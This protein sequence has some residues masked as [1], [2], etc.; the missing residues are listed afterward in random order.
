MTNTATTIT[1][2]GVNGIQ[3]NGVVV[4]PCN[5]NSQSPKLVQIVNDPRVVSAPSPLITHKVRELENTPGLRF[6]GQVIKIP[7][8]KVSFLF[9]RLLSQLA[10]QATKNI[11]TRLQKPPPEEQILRPPTSELDE[12]GAPKVAQGLK[13][14][15]WFLSHLSLCT[16][17]RFVSDAFRPEY[18]GISGAVR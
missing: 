8:T 17:E 1:A 12:T 18:P 16:P 11:E 9:R 6:R 14:Q 13:Q 4:A 5:T 2:P 7:T 10:V 15:A 3:M